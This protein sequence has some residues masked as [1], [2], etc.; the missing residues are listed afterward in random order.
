MSVQGSSAHSYISNAELLAWMSKHTGEL[1]AEMAEAMD[2][3]DRRGEIIKKLSDIKTELNGI[4]KDG[5]KGEA[6]KQKMQELLDEYKDHPA[7]EEIAK[8]LNPIIDRLEQ[9]KQAWRAEHPAAGNPA[10]LLHHSPGAQLPHEFPSDQSNPPSG[11]GS[12]ADLAPKAQDITKWQSN[13]DALNDE[14][15]SQDRTAMIQIQDLSSRANQAMQLASNLIA[16]SHE[17]AKTAIGN[18][19]G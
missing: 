6:A 8:E 4:D 17:A 13:I 18:I 3:A 10:P 16:S 7:A 12:Y 19:R 14:F 9:A 1:N 15:E 11:T 2:I 5:A